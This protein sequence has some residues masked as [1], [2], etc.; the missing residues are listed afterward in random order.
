[1][2]LMVMRMVE[3]TDSYG[4][5]DGSDVVLLDTLVDDPL[6]P[7]RVFPATRNEE[8]A[9]TDGKVSLN[10]KSPLIGGFVPRGALTQVEPRIPTPA[11]GSASVRRTSSHLSRGSSAGA[12]R[13][14]RT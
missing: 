10:L 5:L 7:P 14:E 1:M 12:T 2:G 4:F 13:R 9:F 8:L 6:A 3:G 11:Q